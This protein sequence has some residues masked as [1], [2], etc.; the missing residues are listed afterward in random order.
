[1]YNS[2]YSINPQNKI[3]LNLLPQTIRVDAIYLLSFALYNLNLNF[4]FYTKIYDSIFYVKKYY[5]TFHEYFL[6][7]RRYYQ[8]DD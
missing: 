8:V 6:T 3:C 4:K 2:L 5:T 7:Y 1:M